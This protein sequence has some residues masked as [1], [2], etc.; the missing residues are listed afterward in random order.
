MKIT[1]SPPDKTLL[2]LNSPT[3]FK[4]MSRIL[5]FIDSDLIEIKQN[6]SITR[7]EESTFTVYLKLVI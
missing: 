7:I 2:E 4:I 3:E 6:L 1:F 5:Y